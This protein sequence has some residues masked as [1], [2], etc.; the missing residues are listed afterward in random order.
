MNENKMRDR[1]LEIKN[2][3]AS[4][5]GKEILKG[6]DLSIGSVIAL[7]GCL[8]PWLLTQHGWS[9]WAAV[10]F[11]LGLG[12]LLGLLHGLLI[13]QL[14][15]QPFIVTSAAAGGSPR[16]PTATGSR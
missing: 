4:V 11:V 5:E 10:P 6:I 12:L 15:I 1:M 3:H 16:R 13:T 9:P 2:L 7:V 8:L 14:G